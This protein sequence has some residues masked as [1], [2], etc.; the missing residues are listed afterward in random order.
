MEVGNL[1][2][3][4][5]VDDVEFRNKL[6]QAQQLL[7][8]F[9]T[10]LMRDFGNFGLLQNNEITNSGVEGMTQQFSA[11]GTE[12]GNAMLAGI[13][14]SFVTGF[15]GLQKQ[16]VGGMQTMLGVLMQESTAFQAVGVGMINAMQAGVMARANALT[17]QVVNAVQAALAAANA[18]LG[19]ASA[20]VTG[21]SA[22]PS[23]GGAG[24]VYAKN[25]IGG[26]TGKIGSKAAT[27]T[28][29]SQ[30][31]V[32]FDFKDTTLTTDRLRDAI[33]LMYDVDPTYL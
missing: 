15:G 14:G 26:G 30:T 21:S 19:K 20:T 8:E 4:L 11:I 12:L 25:G 22:T 3:K 5:S 16:L 24:I 13:Q 33:A 27:K 9:E 29:H 1:T 28:I 23:T 18:A 2:V 7:S 10:G 17:A 31:T 6:L 32:N